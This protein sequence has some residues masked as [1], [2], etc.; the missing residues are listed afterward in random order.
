MNRSFLA[1]FVRVGLVALA[2]ASASCR[3]GQTSGPTTLWGE[4][5]IISDEGGVQVGG[6]DGTYDFGTVPMGT[7]LT[8][9]VTVQNVG[10]GAL[11]ID[12]FSKVSGDAVQL[13]TDVTE[14]NPIF[15]LHSTPLTIAS[16]E[17]QTFDL[18]F[19]PP[20]D[21]TAMSV[22][23][24]SVIVLHA[25]NTAPQLKSTARLT[26]RGTAVSGQCDVDRVV[27]FGAVARG[28]ALTKTLVVRNAQPKDVTAFVCGKPQEPR[29][30]VHPESP[31]QDQAFALTAD[32]PRDSFT[33][34]VGKSRT[35]SLAFS[36]TEVRAYSAVLTVRVADQCPDVKVRLL[37]SG[38]SQVVDWACDPSLSGNSA[39]CDFGYVP[40]RQQTTAKV[41]FSNRSL[42]EVHLT[43]LN[44][45][46]VNGPTSVY[47]VTQANA[48]DLTSLT[49][50]A[51]TRDALS[52]NVNPGTASATVTFSPA[53][54]G[55]RPAFLNATSDANGGS[56][57]L[58]VALRGFGGGPNIAVK[59]NPLVFGRIAYFANAVPASSAT[60]RLTVLNSGTRPP[61]PD[62]KANLKLGVGGKPAT[63]GPK[64]WR[65][66]AKNAQTSVGELCV[67]A[68]FDSSGLCLD[69]L[70]A[71]GQGAYDP[72]IGLDAA[73][74]NGVLDIAVQV[75]PNSTDSKAWELTLYSN[76]SDQ[77]EVVIPITADPVV[78]PSCTVSVTPTNVNF[79][80]ITP[81]N[82]KD[83]AFTIQNL[84]PTEKCLL[85]NID[86]AA[87][88]NPVFSLP[89]GAV[90]EHELNPL[91]VMTVLVR[92][93]PVGA[94]PPTP[95]TVT[96]QVAFNVANP[97]MPTQQVTLT[98]TLAPNCLVIAP[99]DLDFGTVQMGCSSPDRAFQLYNTCL[100]PIT[101]QSATMVMPAGVPGGAPGCPG[102]A[103]CPE[104]IAVNTS[105]LTGSLDQNDAPKS[106]QLK[107]R[108]LDLGADTG[109]F[110]VKVVQ[111]GQP[112]DYVITL[113]GVGDASGFN[114]DVFQQELRPKADI[115]LVVDD[116]CSM[117][118][119]QR[120]LGDNLA[121]F[122]SY[123]TTNQVDFRIGLVTTDFTSTYDGYF[124]SGPP[125]TG[126]IAPIVNRVITPDTPNLKAEFSSFVNVG[127]AGSGVESCMEPAT[128]AL[129]APLVN[130]V[131]ANGGFLRDDAVLAVVCVTDATDNAPHLPPYYLT[132]LQNIKGAQKPSL[133]TYNVIGPF[134]ASAPAGECKYD[135]SASTGDDGKHTFM[136][137]STGGIKE[138]ICSADWSKALENVG[139][140]AF[141]Y[142]TNFF[143]NATPDL[144]VAPPAIVVTVD[145]V[146][147]PQVDTSNGATVW[148]YDPLS[149]SVVFQPTYLP[150]PGRTMTV[151]YHVVCH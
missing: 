45:T 67:G 100:A 61:T 63:S 14:A 110:L 23:R 95:T 59:P 33:I 135:D 65:V 41:T 109:G 49:V 5:R 107:Y 94:L 105:G 17:T 117:A 77:P 141:G 12:S 48:Q 150:E 35:V 139:K 6:D 39:T 87:G 60:R 136:V 52:G 134:L 69:D 73:G 140:K 54:L 125:N 82:T 57:K 115:L 37:G 9:Q 15:T 86:L 36:P 70:P 113:R 98:A 89:A 71:I 96:G 119:K 79:G 131:A 106:F 120:S 126:S 29:D 11:N 92:A 148:S 4:I 108:P 58:V 26:L 55:A 103:D 130:D 137:A 68:Q 10:R 97:S 138:E 111:S 18:D 8:R 112:I 143:L 20:L 50:P 128:R 85:T 149:N 80:V 38:V 81:P 88:S 30:C 99:R 1:S 133:L 13:G 27:D 19:T 46:D 56:E 122:I 121:S 114:T 142:R 78:V 151:S 7:K 102:P 147:L 2:F 84:S 145:G 72:V 75:T 25:S 116:S 24:E 44:V 76:D 129:T 22:A 127:T 104:F 21:E 74:V 3:C 42:S 16:G 83:L 124:R 93:T 40:P 43:G 51:G 118:D 123:A 91:E 47:K 32:S 146:S 144:A 132:Q 101:I 28:S 62:P 64:Y 66:V 90:D 34:G 31:T 53:V